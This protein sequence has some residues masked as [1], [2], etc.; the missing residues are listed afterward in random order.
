MVEVRDLESDA[1]WHIALPGIEGFRVLHEGDL[2]EFWG[3]VLSLVI[4]VTAGGW[5]KQELSRGGLPANG[6]EMF[7][8]TL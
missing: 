2:G 7:E 6:L 4:E 8:S 5:W 3:H 1:H